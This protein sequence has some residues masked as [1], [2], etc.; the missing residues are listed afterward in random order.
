MNPRG[1]SVAFALRGADGVEYSEIDA[2]VFALQ[3]GLPCRSGSFDGWLRVM[4]QRQVSLAIR[5][6]LHD[7]IPSVCEALLNCQPNTSTYFFLGSMFCQYRVKLEGHIVE[8]AKAT[9][10]LYGERPAYFRRTELMQE[11]RGCAQRFEQVLTVL[12]AHN[13]EW[14]SSLQR[15]RGVLRKF[16]V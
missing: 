16:V 8:I 5:D 13:A 11:L 14:Q 15:L 6:D 1:L 9:P 4:Q 12:A 2:K 10:P 3:G 7:L